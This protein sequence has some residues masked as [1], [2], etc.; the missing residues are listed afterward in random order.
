V[1]EFVIVKIFHLAAIG[2]IFVCKSRAETRTWKVIPRDSI[3]VE[4]DST[5]HV[6]EIGG[7]S[8]WTGE[9]GAYL[10]ILVKN[11]SLEK[12]S[13]DLVVGQIVTH[14]PKST[15]ASTAQT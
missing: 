14:I 13:R 10:D 15:D 5:K 6:L 7:I 11:K 1:I 12:L 4:L 3:E 2:K 8:F 9:D